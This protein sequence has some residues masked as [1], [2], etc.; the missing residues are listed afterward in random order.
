MWRVSRGDGVLLSDGERRGGLDS[1][2]VSFDATQLNLD[3][4][5]THLDAVPVLAGE[6]VLGL[7]LEALLALG[8][9]L[10]PAPRVS[11]IG[12]PPD[13]RG[14]LDIVRP[15][16]DSILRGGATYLPTA[17]LTSSYVNGGTDVLLG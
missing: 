15:V 14:R 4:T 5:A 17:I 1:R 3:G 11:A 8:Q 13:A 10:V 12:N 16:P 6:G 2:I 7:L 9:S